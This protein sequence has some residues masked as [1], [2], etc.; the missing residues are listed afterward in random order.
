MLTTVPVNLSTIP[1]TRQAYES[2]FHLLFEASDEQ[3]I[4]QAALPAELQLHE[5]IQDWLKDATVPGIL[6]RL[7]QS[8][9]LRF[10][11]DLFYGLVGTL[12]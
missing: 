7:G 6:A 4:Y 1:S 3:S 11:P 12:S 10:E 5:Y 2:V 8:T 9:A